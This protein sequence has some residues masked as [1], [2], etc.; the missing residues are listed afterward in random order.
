[1]KAILS[2]QGIGELLNRPDIYDS[3]I[4]LHDSRL[5]SIFRPV[6]GSILESIFSWTYLHNEFGT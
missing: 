5:T 6:S 4:S 3:A 1:M 2:K